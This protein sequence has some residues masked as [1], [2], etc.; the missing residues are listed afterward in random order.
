M[1]HVYIFL[2]GAA[3]LI[4][5]IALSR[6]LI[7]VFGNGLQATSTI[8]CAYMIGLAAGA[9]IAGKFI[10][11]M[12]NGLRVYG[13]V[14]LAIAALGLVIPLLFSTQVIY[15]L[16]S[17][18]PPMD[19]VAGVLARLCWS[20]V[21]M[22][23]LATLIGATY[24]ILVCVA[25]RVFGQRDKP[26]S[27]LYAVNTAGAV[28]GTIC[29]AFVLIPEFGLSATC[30]VA[31]A[32][33]GLVG[34]TVLAAPPSSRLTSTT[35]SRPDAGPPRTVR[36][37][38][39]AA[40]V[41]AVTCGFIAMWLEVVWTRL[42]SLVLGD[43]T[44]AFATV[45]SIVLLGTACG[46][47]LAARLTDRNTA[48]RAVLVLFLLGLSIL[49][50]LWF[51][52]E[53]PLL[54]A[55]LTKQLDQ[56]AIHK[57]WLA[58]AARA[59]LVA[60]VVFPTSFLSGMMFPFAIR[61]GARP[62]RDPEA[63]AGTV[64]G[65]NALGAVSGALVA[66]F[67]GIPLLSRICT[68]G[69]QIS[70]LI[71]GLLS[72]IVAAYVATFSPSKR[73]QMITWASAI[74][75]VFLVLT[76]LPKW[77]PELMTSGLALYDWQTLAR[78]E[79]ETLLKKLGSQVSADAPR[80]EFYKEGLNSTVSVTTNPSTNV[81]FLRTDGKV[82]GGVATDPS[83]PAP[84]SDSTTQVLLGE[85]PLRLHTGVP[86]RV[87]V[88]GYGTGTTSGSILASTSVRELTI[89]ELERSVLEADPYFAHANGR[90]LRREWILSGRT[91]PRAIDGR[92]LLAAEKDKFDVIV[93]Q[94]AEPWVAGSAD[95]Y[96]RE[97]WNTAKSKLAADGIFCQ[98]V[99]LYSVTPEYLAV[100]TRTFTT[101]FPQA[102][103][104]LPRGAGELILVGSGRPI[105]LDPKTLDERI[106]KYWT[107]QQ[108]QDF[109]SRMRE[110]FHR[111]PVNTDDN[112][113]TE[114]K[115]APQLYE[116]GDTID[117]NIRALNRD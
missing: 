6:L 27:T 86:A 62:N 59:M 2:S 10:G 77:Q 21:F 114:Y 82:E 39:T 20:A 70:I 102:I 36:S 11:R 9:M 79:R 14:E 31:A 74:L 24:P 105:S 68:S 92:N 83:K 64:Y 75:A 111:S 29:G 113:L 40:I 65:T 91:K 96:T 53:L 51:I 106:S 1:L 85:L 107:P 54:F 45:L 33:N 50:S 30:L 63:V 15:G 38:S 110:K 43:T 71:C 48:I 41:I 55:A 80:T 81:T 115:L 56:F 117:E 78:T 18:L 22:L 95:L 69:I 99:Q 32:I 4:Y 73:R 98:W 109:D 37:A 26:G 3:G 12:S 101:V 60:A 44:Y 23:P 17:I 52:A 35:Q 104:F 49:G 28:M 76:L 84:T 42:F 97:F 47:A 66:G 34:L 61:L 89:A 5:E 7:H 57:F 25:D 103:A 16:S 87:L 108:L 94:P 8:L 90:P 88:I 46:A 19:Q 72:L 116:F 13:V 112:L 67:A 58:M 100:L 93:S